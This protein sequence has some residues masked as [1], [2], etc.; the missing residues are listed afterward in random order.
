[1]WEERFIFYFS[2]VFNLRH[3]CKWIYAPLLLSHLLPGWLGVTCTADLCQFETTIF[4]NTIRRRQAHCRRQNGKKA[5]KAVRLCYF[6]CA[7]NW[8][9]IYI[10][11]QI[12]RYICICSGKQTPITHAT[13]NKKSVEQNNKK[14]KQQQANGKSIH[15]SLTF[16]CRL[17]IKSRS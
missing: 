17:A 2:R 8:N 12:R 14:K 4:W 3:I 1:M 6:G 7:F 15:I 11:A 10:C 9:T 16:R 13:G 5:K